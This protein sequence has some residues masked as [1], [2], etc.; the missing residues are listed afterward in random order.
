MLQE[1]TKEGKKRIRLI[2]ILSVLFVVVLTGLYFVIAHARQI[3]KEIEGHITDAVANIEQGVLKI[4]DT[5]EMFISFY[6]LIEQADS[7]AHSV[8]IDEESIR[9]EDP[10][11]QFE[12]A[13][14]ECEEA[15]TLYRSALALY[16]EAWQL[17][18]DLSYSDGTSTASYGI[19]EMYFI[20]A[21]VERRIEILHR[22]E[23]MRLAEI[24]RLEEE[25]RA[26][27]ERLEEERRAEAQ[28]AEAELAEAIRTK[29][30]QYAQH[31]EAL[32]NYV[33]NLGIKF[34]LSTMVT[35][36]N[37]RPANQIRMGTAEGLNE[38]WYNG[39]GWIAAY[40]A[41]IRLGNPQHPAEIVWHFET[42]GGTVLGGVFG[43]YPHS[44]EA[45]FK[46]LGYDVKHTL[47]PQVTLDIDEAIKTSGVSILAYLHSGAAHYVMV[48]YREDIDKFVVYNDSFARRRSTDL[49]F[50]SLTNTG[51]AIDSVSALIKETSEII[52]SF[53]LITIS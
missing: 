22:N 17:A 44:I 34:D 21:G 25:R 3:Q 53:S 29:A 4:A 49:G 5:A 19:I 47:F 18:L 11:L 10:V 40:N 36:Q 52:I 8:I 50:Q 33:H 2:I 23:A 13:V 39:C 7:I 38:G 14:A 20:I 41:L 16:N 42:S 46:S 35:N 30:E 27:A 32:A 48:E 1:S 9:F 51:S 26:E 31:V 24:E 45:Y 6:A 37:E 43:T 28:R 12:T 15:I